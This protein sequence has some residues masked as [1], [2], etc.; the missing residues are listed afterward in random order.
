MS[1][2]QFT[3][4]IRLPFARGDFVDPPQADWNAAKDRAL[5][6]VISKSPKTSDLNWAELA[7]RFQVPP[8]FLL[9]QAA[10]LYERHLEHVRSQMKKV[11]GGGGGASMPSN[12]GSAVPGGIPMQRLGSA[13]SRASRTPSALSVRPRDSPVARGDASIYVSSGPPPAPPLSRTPSTNTITQSKA[14]SQQI[15]LRTQSQRTARPS[16]T[17]PRPTAPIRTNSQNQADSQDIGT[18]SVAASSSSSSSSSD[19]DDLD[20][21]AHRSQLFK[22]PPR[23]QKQRPRELSAYDEEPE[24]DV[25]DFAQSGDGSLPFAQ[26]PKD[27]GPAGKRRHAPHHQPTS[28]KSRQAAGS[29]K[30][31]KS[32]DA[33]SSLASSASDAPRPS[34]AGH[35]PLSPRHRAE[36][37][38]LSPRGRG[39]REGS[40]GTPSMGSSFSDIDDAGISQSALEEAL[41]SNIQHGRMSTLSQ[42]RSRYL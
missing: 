23:F 10:W 1:A 27:A 11:G 36:L 38:R 6:K 2:V 42:L 12:S 9:Q 8:A 29:S 15:P 33:S 19:S 24:D 13:G 32:M 28:D 25:D 20:N 18:V 22:R 21:P 31:P 7:V 40:D 30:Y 35:G 41:L 37:A 4:L 17:S 5:W 3:T 26:G 16:I 14:T 34:T 39:K